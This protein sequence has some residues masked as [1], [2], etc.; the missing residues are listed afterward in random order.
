MHPVIAKALSNI[1]C[2]FETPRPI[3]L[4]LPTEFEVEEVFFNVHVRIDTPTYNHR[5]G[6]LKFTSDEARLRFNDNMLR[7]MAVVGMGKD[8][9]W[10]YPDDGCE[11]EYLHC[12][13]D[14]ISGVISAKRIG[15]L[16]RE[17]D[18]GNYGSTIRWVDVYEPHELIS[19]SE[20]AKRVNFYESKIR[21]T[22]LSRCETSRKT[23]FVGFQLASMVAN[24]PGFSFAGCKGIGG[25][26]EKIPES[27][28]TKLEAILQELETVGWLNTMTQNGQ[29]Y[30][31]TSNKTEQRAR[32][33]L[34]RSP[35][36]AV[37]V[38]N[39]S[40]GALL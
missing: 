16:V 11:Y 2:E 5:D 39:T 1:P 19:D 40:Q 29:T 9:G 38:G 7:L 4:S 20:V 36:P 37:Y 6:C 24:C 10:Y 35:A 18:T 13:P 31:R 26:V 12:H 15:Q 34:K 14:D 30:Y 33:L 3:T 22:V 23:K 21:E 8:G 27:L 32:G 28:V 25:Y 17:L